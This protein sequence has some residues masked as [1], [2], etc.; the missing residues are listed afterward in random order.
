MKIIREQYMRRTLLVIVAVLSLF[1]LISDTIIYLHHRSTLHSE[2]RESRGQELRLLAI[3]SRDAFLE[4]DR[5]AIRKL[6]TQWGREQHRVVELKISNREGGLVAD[7]QRAASGPSSIKLVQ[8][9]ELGDSQVM[10]LELAADTSEVTGSLDVMLLQ[11]V[12]ISIFLLLIMAAS[13]W[14]VLRR[15]AIAPLK[16]EVLR[17]KKIL[18][19]LRRVS[20]EKQRLL[21]SAG[22]GIFSIQ[23]D[24]VCTFVND[25]ALALLGFKRSEILGKN[26]HNLIH[27]TDSNGMQ[28]Q[29]ETCQI[30]S[31]LSKGEGVVV[32][33]DCFWRGD[34]ASF[35]VMYSAFPLDEDGDSAGAVVVFHD[36]T[37]Q[38]TERKV[39]EHQ[40]SH[41]PLTGLVNRRE[42]ERRLERAIETAR[43]QDKEHVLLYLDL[44]DFK[45]V[46]DT[47]GHQAGDELLRRIATKIGGMMRERDTLA[48]LGGDEFAVL[49]EHCFME[50]ALRISSE[51]I[52][53]VCREKFSWDGKQFV[54]G[55]SIGL[56]EVDSGCANSD[57]AI[58]AADGAC[59][60]AKQLGGCQVQSWS[61]ALSA[62]N[63]VH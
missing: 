11:L 57:A 7:F 24:C 56:A 1:L 58:D 3:V 52:D 53:V 19:R 36:I 45:L 31:S 16:D 15:L 48:R 39:L 35:P 13:I 37:K 63:K 49:L 33:E 42:F 22:E 62:N 54:I 61:P 26:I 38:Q 4:P 20:R 28:C 50:V 21:E 23:G 59:Y 2:F 34:G 44:D 51:I 40:A 8:E 60:L 12:V 9:L 10:R 30:L 47:V 25:A 46:N 5:S 32:D 27:H 17:R 18:N 41:D 14:A 6:V 43:E 55:V 29:P